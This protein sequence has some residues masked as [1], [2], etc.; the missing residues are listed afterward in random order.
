MQ[1]LSNFS[2]EE[3]LQ[4]V[5]SSPSNASTQDGSND[6][7]QFSNEELIAQLQSGSGNKFLSSQPIKEIKSPISNIDRLR[8][9]FADDEG[10][11][12]FLRDRFQFV[13]K[14]EATGKYVVGNSLKDA[15]PIDPNTGLS[16]V[17]GDLADIVGEIP[18]IAGQIIGGGLGTGLNP[19]LGTIAGGTVGVGVGEATKIGIGKALGVQKGSFEEDATDVAI[20][21]AFGLAGESLAKGT[22]LAFKKGKVLA[23]K[24]TKILSKAS[25]AQAV[26]KGISPE[27]TPVAVAAKKAFNI[28]SN[29]PEDST[30][31][32]FKNGIEEVFQPQ[33]LKKE[34]VV[35]LSA[36]LKEALSH[37]KNVRGKEVEKQT[38][39]LIKKSADPI[40]IAPLY[41]N[42]RNQMYE[43]GLID[44]TGN[45]SRT[46]VGKENVSF[47]KR[48]MSQ[49]LGSNKPLNNFPEVAQL[50]KNV[51]ELIRMRRQLSDS[52]PGLSNKF[53]SSVQSFVKG[54]KQNPGIREL[55][56]Q[57]ASKVGVK[58]YLK[59][60]EDY[61]DM[62]DVYDTLNLTKKTDVNQLEKVIKGLEKLGENQKVSFEKLRRM[63]PEEGKL[64]REVENWNA[65]QD[66]T[67]ARP[68]IL[69]FSA[70]TGIL[71]GLTGFESR[72]DKV[73]TIAGALTLGTPAGNRVIMQLLN[74]AGKIPGSA[75]K[76]SGKAFAL[77]NRIEA[78]PAAA[79]Q[80]LRSIFEK[81]SE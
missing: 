37:V 77:S 42:L 60:T 1:D 47:A 7:S 45:I 17:F 54:S 32:V 44:S 8:L 74:K 35:S 5:Q 72:E 50:N 31:T 62:M 24:L 49:I 22:S 13:Q 53:Q 69:R 4:R 21:T 81:G 79:S 25:K 76:S 33:N 56:N 40:D 80:A 55:V 3:L 28:L 46:A 61:F 39:K 23:P 67:S 20:S 10:R 27:K 52:Y 51:D 38:A 71:A 14:D 73:T 12:A 48:M 18:A 2:T 65:A 75:I 36:K 34:T 70:I 11:E 57:R 43:L 29:V 68:N 30:E 9:G 64:L 6:L 15:M 16:D 41:N 26:K 63:L 59:A 19:G 58:G 78:T 66:F